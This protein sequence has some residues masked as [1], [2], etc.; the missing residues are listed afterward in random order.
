MGARYDYTGSL[1]EGSGETGPTPVFGEITRTLTGSGN[2]VAH[3]DSYSLRFMDNYYDSFMINQHMV[4]NSNETFQ[5]SKEQETSPT[6]ATNAE[7]QRYVGYD[8]DV[9]GLILVGG[10]RNTS[11]HVIV[12]HDGAPIYDETVGDFDFYADSEPDFGFRDTYDT[13]GFLAPRVGPTHGPGGDEEQMFTSATTF[14]GDTPGSTG[15]SWVAFVEEQDEGGEPQEPITDDF[16]DKPILTPSELSALLDVDPSLT[17]LD[18]D[19]IK[20]MLREKLAI[21]I[22]NFAVFFAESYG[23]TIR[24]VVY[25]YSPG[26][27]GPYSRG[28]PSYFPATSEFSQVISLSSINAVSQDHEGDAAQLYFLANAMLYTGLATAG[29]GASAVIGAIVSRG[30]GAGIAVGAG[31]VAAEAMG[32]PINPIQAADTLLRNGTKRV[33][34]KFATRNGASAMSPLR[35]EEK[36]IES[37]AHVSKAAS[38]VENIG[39]PADVA[40]AASRLGISIRSVSVADQIATARIG[41]AHRL[42]LADIGMLKKYF[43]SQGTT[44]AVVYSRSSHQSTIEGYTLGLAKTG[45]TFGGARVEIVDEILGTFR[46]VFLTLD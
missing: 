39:F 19:Q 27:P 28:E 7:G 20:S 46:L 32:L 3:A 1:I 12:W 11:D 16:G 2:A 34:Q 21:Q 42:S 30:I 44:K 24:L 22:D 23:G 38:H 17:T 35:I 15:A 14:T 29:A 36:V 25:R 33:V 4:I 18:V 10:T 13:V 40:G 9:T 5:G 37:A 26:H 8:V 41:F 31:E 45:R 43:A 6:V